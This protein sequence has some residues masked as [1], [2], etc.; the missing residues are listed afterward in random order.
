MAISRFKFTCVRTKRF[1]FFFF[2]SDRT[3]YKHD[4][5]TILA[6]F[7]Q[8][9]LVIKAQAEKRLGLAEGLGGQP[10]ENDEHQAPDRTGSMRGD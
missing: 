10:W 7:F 2:L 5:K 4:V 9:R 3:V 6:V 1:F 8:G